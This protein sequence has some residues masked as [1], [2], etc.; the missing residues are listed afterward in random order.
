MTGTDLPAIVTDLVLLILGAP[1]SP[2]AVA[3]VTTV[4]GSV[5][6]TTALTM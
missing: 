6:R 5:D 3:T 1:P 2:T 4:S